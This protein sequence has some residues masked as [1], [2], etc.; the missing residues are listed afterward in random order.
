MTPSSL[1]KY[2]SHVKICKYPEEGMFQ[3]IN[4]DGRFREDFDDSSG[5]IAVN[6]SLPST[7]VPHCN[8]FTERVHMRGHNMHF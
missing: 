7:V 5:V 4:Q 6:C 3:S 2:S 1:K 8:S